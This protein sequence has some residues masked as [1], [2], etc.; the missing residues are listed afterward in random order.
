MKKCIGCGE[1][2]QNESRLIKGYS[3]DL[4][5]DYCERCFR[6]THYND[7]TLDLRD[8]ILPKDVFAMLKD[9]DDVFVLVVDVLN[10]EA[11]FKDDLLA[12]LKHKHLI[13][14]ISKCDLLPKT[15]NYAKFENNLINYLRDKL[16]DIDVLDLIL[17]SKNDYNFKKLFEDTLKRH[18]INKVCFIGN[19][20]A[21]KSSLINKL[22]PNDKL[23]T[24]YFLTTTLA[25]NT[26]KINDYELV[27]S[28][29]FVDENNIYMTLN[30]EELQKIIIKKA[31]KPKVYQLYEPQSY[32][33][34]ALVRIDAF[35][36][37]NASIIFYVNNDLYLHRTHFD[38][39][40]RY[41][42][43]HF[44][45]IIFNED[46]LIEHKFV[47]NG[48]NNDIIIDGLGFISV[49][50]IDQLIITTNRKIGVFKRKGMF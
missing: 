27:D 11:A 23:T 14:L 19:S 43:A 37:N 50:N 13:L 46:D 45:N 17:S 6:L 7:L 5:K 2:L 32:F 34:D 48:E 16:V 35:T 15:L 31:I 36:K 29:G 3:Y 33:I 40:V 49:K 12:F 4:G 22:L 9:L 47:I 10:I 25:L 30:K 42:A 21:G 41:Q 44:N 8:A 24:S 20:N 1:I 39:G 26:I 38:N 28:P 18:H